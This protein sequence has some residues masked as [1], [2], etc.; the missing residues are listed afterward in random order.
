MSCTAFILI[1]SKNA[2]ISDATYIFGFMEML[3]FCTLWIYSEP[4]VSK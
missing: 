4:N 2:K 3:F 1:I